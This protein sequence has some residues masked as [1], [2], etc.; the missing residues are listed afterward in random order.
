MVEQTKEEQ[1][2]I[3]LNAM[4]QKCAQLEAENDLLKAKPEPRQTVQQ[5]FVDDAPKVLPSKAVA[6]AIR[7]GNFKAVADLI[8]HVDV[9]DDA[10]WRNFQMKIHLDRAE[11]C[12][13]PLI[14]KSLM[15]QAMIEYYGEDYDIEQHED[16]LPYSN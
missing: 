7:V 3:L 11:K 5:N 14:K 16:F 13:D 8:D 2:Q 10:N 15:R 9:D 12:K 4:R 1:L 6:N